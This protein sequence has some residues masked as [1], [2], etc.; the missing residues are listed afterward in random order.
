MRSASPPARIAAIFTVAAISAAAGVAM[1]QTPDPPSAG[2]WLAALPE[3]K[4]IE[5]IDR[6]LRGFDMA[7]VETG[8][9]YAEM[10]FAVKNGNWDFA[11]YNAQ[12][13]AVAIMNGYERRPKRR[14]NSE[15]L[16]LKGVYPEVLATIRAKDS[17]A[18]EARFDDMTTQCNACHAAE[19]LPFM[20]VAKPTQKLSPIAD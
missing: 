16:F 18:F 15:A 2:G 13:L 1:A 11:L 3:D 4:R 14:A 12:K 9:R 6:Q 19:N 10:Y 5:A 17:S 20:K 8:Y 7:M